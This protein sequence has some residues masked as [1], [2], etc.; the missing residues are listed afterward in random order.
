MRRRRL[1]YGRLYLV[2]PGV[3]APSLSAALPPLHGRSTAH[4]HQVRLPAA[5]VQS[6]RPAALGLLPTL[7]ADVALPARLVALSVSHAGLSRRP[8]APRLHDAATAAHQ[9]GSRTAAPAAQT[10]HVAGTVSSPLSI[11]RH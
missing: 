9:P 6:L 1:W 5:G 4:L 10:R 11:S 8:T 7:L 2:R 3:P